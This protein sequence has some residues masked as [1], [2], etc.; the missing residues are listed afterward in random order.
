MHVLIAISAALMLWLFLPSLSVAQTQPEKDPMLA[1]EHVKQGAY[2]IDVRSPE[3]FNNGHLAGAINVPY[4]LIV[5]GM[6]KYNLGPDTPVVL[7]CRSGRRSGVAQ[8]ALID[9]GYTSTYN[10]GGYLMLMEA[11]NANL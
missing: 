11:K 9:A 8:Q 1:L 3:E 7:Y 10:G 5:E 6:A 4:Q 2:L